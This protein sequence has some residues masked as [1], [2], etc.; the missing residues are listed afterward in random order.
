MKTNLNKLKFYKL[1]FKRVYYDDWIRDDNGDLAFQ[2]KDVKNKSFILETLN[3]N[4][5]QYLETLSLS[6]SE[7]NSNVI[8]NNNKPF[9]A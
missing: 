6:I 2:I 5:S 8:L 4:Q 9:I 1:P 7:D 3:G